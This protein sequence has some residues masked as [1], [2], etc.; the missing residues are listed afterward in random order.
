MIGD[1]NPGITLI[2]LLTPSMI[3]ATKTTVVALVLVLVLVV[4]VAVVEQ[5]Q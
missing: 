4:V 2:M 3:P 1:I 5:Q